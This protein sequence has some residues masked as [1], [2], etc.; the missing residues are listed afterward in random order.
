MNDRREVDGSIVV[1]VCAVEGCTYWR[2]ERTT[3]VHVTDNPDDWRGRTVTHEL[4]AVRY[5]PDLP[6]GSV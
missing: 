3:G 2:Q 6:G 5:V 4:V 1:H